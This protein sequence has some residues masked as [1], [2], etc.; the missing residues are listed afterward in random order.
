MAQTCNKIR[1]FTFLS[2]RKIEGMLLTS[3][4]TKKTRFRTHHPHL[5]RRIWDLNTCWW[6]MMKN[7]QYLLRVTFRAFLR[8]ENCGM[9]T[10]MYKSFNIYI[11]ITLT[12]L[13]LCSS[14]CPRLFFFSTYLYVCMCC[15]W[16]TL[17]SHAAIILLDQLISK[18][19]VK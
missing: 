11:K 13:H 14:L 17:P 16:M 12:C 5:L 2:L 15:C 6:W 8:K 19:N 9:T 3:I 18:V 4:P 1:R 7:V 10:I